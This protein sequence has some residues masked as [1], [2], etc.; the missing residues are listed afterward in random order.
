MSRPMP[1]A[2]GRR[3]RL[4]ATVVLLAAAPLSARATPVDFDLVG[5]AGGRAIGSEYAWLHIAATG[6]GTFV[7]FRPDSLT[8][9]P[10]DSVA[11]TLRSGQVDTLWQSIT[12]N[13]YFSLASSYADLSLID[14]SFAS[15]TIRGNGI[16]HS[17]NTLNTP[18]A[19][20]DAVMAA[21][22][23]LTPGALDLVYDNAALPDFTP[24]DGCGNTSPAEFPNDAR[25]PAK[26]RSALV[27]RVRPNAVQAIQ[28]V[29]PDHAGTTVA[30]HMP[31]DQAVGRGIA[32]LTSKGNFFGDGVTITID[33]TAGV[34]TSDL[35][36]DLYL[37]LYGPAADAAAQGA[38][39]T[40]IQNL[41]GGHP[42]SGGQT[43]A[44]NVNSTLT[45]GLTPPGTAGFHQVLL[46]NPNTT[47]A[48]TR[49][50]C[51]VLGVPNQGATSIKMN[52]LPNPYATAPIYPHEAGHLMGLPDRYTSYYKQPDGTWSKD[53]G[54]TT[55]PVDALAMMLQPRFPGKTLSEIEAILAQDDITFVTVPLPGHEND[56]MG[57][58]SGTAL[59]SDID[60]L[61]AKAG[62]VVDI[63]VGTV[64]CDKS[65]PAQNLVVTRERHVFVAKG[66]TRTI[67]GLWVA[68][69]DG[70]KEAPDFGI[71][72][73][74]VPPLS[75][76]T[77]Y[78]AAAA[79]QKLLDYVNHNRLYCADQINTQD[80]I[81]D[82]S[83]G[84]PPTPAESPLLVAAGVS[85][86][87][88][89]GFPHFFDP[90]TDGVTRSVLPRAL[91]APLIAR[92][93]GDVVTPG[94]NVA[95]TGSSGMAVPGVSTSVGG[96]TLARPAGSAAT[97]SQT[98]GPTSSFHADVRG[99]Y[100]IGLHANVTALSESF[101]ID[102]VLDVTCAD[103]YTE[104]FES[105]TIRAGAPFHWVTTGDSLWMPYV[106]S[107]TGTYGIVAPT[108]P[109]HTSSTIST[110]V[111]LSAPG[112][113]QFAYGVLTAVPTV[114]PSSLVDGVA[115][116]SAL[117]FLVDG[118]VVGSFTNT[119]H[120][121]IASFTIPAGTHTLTWNLHR[122]PMELA[123]AE[124]DDIQF[125]LTT[126]LTAVTPAP[127]QLL[128]SLG[129]GR[130]NPVT[131]ETFIPFT[132]PRAAHVQLAVY[133]LLGRQ[134]ARLADAD[135]TVGTH[136]IRFD[137][138]SLP[139]GL[140]TVRILAG[141]FR[142]VR[143]LV[144]LR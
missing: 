66:Q 89:P 138:S 33:N 73:D 70:H 64:F 101:A 31:I 35:R 42:T 98:N 84:T 63:P 71:G 142:A 69:I 76:W 11:F 12:A 44:C 67:F 13:S 43:L 54:Q 20:F 125:P 29:D 10:L 45:P 88:P 49:G 108:D 32:T 103:A 141:D 21:L 87:P 62:L 6:Q 17:V 78:P 86:P 2:G 34:T 131:R 126:E 121:E 36:M 118:V 139:T 143:S 46:G 8:A 4:A 144:R 30:N 130:P 51:D 109:S 74:L 60:A 22:N 53:G 92:S 39:E 16:T 1:S 52:T 50:G 79:M 99:N 58:S 127:R 5:T 77:G 113:L 40:A 90:V 117:R 96:W 48:V 107:H 106:Y 41:W 9:A 68:C 56:V 102:T 93:P 14:G 134:V 15:L 119:V 115:T 112:S 110:T 57:A 111:T 28:T 132:L 94:Q 120:W 83:E 85:L 61:A 116:S 123:Y 80:A 129:P 140:Y 135:F 95:L 124:L 137:A 75:Q 38:L 47:P 122:D 65:N 3:L 91:F 97:L 81:W 27:T 128:A 72:L 136:E 24:Q 59:Q 133:D 114:A 55:E 7:R 105:G 82:I 104:T 37:D 18:V 19:G 100:R 26:A 23:A 25:L